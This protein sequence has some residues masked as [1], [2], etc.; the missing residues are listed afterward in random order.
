MSDTLERPHINKKIQQLESQVEFDWNDSS[1]LYEVYK[2]LKNRE[3][4]RLLD[5]H[6]VQSRNVILRDRIYDRLKELYFR[7]PN[8]DA[9]GGDGMLSDNH[10]PQEGLLAHMGYHVGDSGEPMGRRQKILDRVYES[11]L[12]RVVNTEYMAEWGEPS[13]AVRLKKMAQSIAAFCRNQKRK[14]GDR[15]SSVKDWE[16]DLA[17]LKWKFYE[18]IYSFDWP[19]SDEYCVV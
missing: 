5:G 13:S 1:A 8:T 6:T 14:S 10:W 17:Y 7:W 19:R 15:S 16:A 2:E 18:G 9:D 12:P 4:K 3:H 11:T